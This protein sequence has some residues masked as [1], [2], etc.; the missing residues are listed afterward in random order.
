VFQAAKYCGLSVASIRYH[1]YRTKNLVPDGRVGR[2]LVFLRPTLDAFKD[3]LRVPG[4]K[5][6]PEPE[7]ARSTPPA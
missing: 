1:V 6:T 7:Q 2:N 3:V 5:A 4:R